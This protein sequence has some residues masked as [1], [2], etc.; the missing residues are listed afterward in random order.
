MRVAAIV[1]S[2]DGILAACGSSSVVEHYLA[3]V[4]VASS[5]LVSRSMTPADTDLNSDQSSYDYAAAYRNPRRVCPKVV[6]HDLSST[7]SH[8]ERC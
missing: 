3:K 2:G 5:S 7:A 6:C 1:T 4:G 8:I